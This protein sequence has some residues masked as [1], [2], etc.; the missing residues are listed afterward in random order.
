MT[1]GEK[2]E[3]TQKQKTAQRSGKP[4][5]EGKKLFSVFEIYGIYVKA[6]RGFKIVKKGRQAGIFDEKMQERIML[7]VTAV[8]KCAMC[9]YAHTEMAL[10]AGLS[11]EEIMSFV[12]SEFPDVPAEQIKAVMFAQHY[13][14]VRGRLDKDSWFE[15]VKEYGAEKA[16]CILAAARIIMM[17]NAMGIV[18]SSIRSRFKGEKNENGKRGDPR[19]NIAYEIL[20]ILSIL[21]IMLFGS[22]QALIMNIFR[23]PFIKFKNEK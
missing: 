21:P 8:N 6:F 18:F 10:K 22:L 9:S 23:V 12:G 16:E 20:F 14:D 5:A 2:T 1:R 19:S 17:G 11:N 7:A 3:M 13:A 15:I 4:A